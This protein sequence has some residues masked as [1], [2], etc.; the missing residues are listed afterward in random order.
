MGDLQDFVRLFKGLGE[1]VV[2]ELMLVM[3][4][5]RETEQESTCSNIS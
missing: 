3:H 5:S 4:K 2:C 1:G